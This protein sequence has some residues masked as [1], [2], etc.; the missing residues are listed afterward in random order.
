MIVLLFTKSISSSYLLFGKISHFSDNTGKWI[1]Y[2]SI[3]QSISTILYVFLRIFFFD[4]SVSL[5]QTC[6]PLGVH[7]L[8]T[9]VIYYRHRI[10]NNELSR[11][12]FKKGDSENKFKVKLLKEHSLELILILMFS[13]FGFS[14]GFLILS[15]LNFL[16]FYK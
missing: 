15:A 14:N 16:K 3:L 8:G 12:A 11:N 6:G 2:L 10:S 4:T 13:V 7:Q 1:F 9:T 5:T